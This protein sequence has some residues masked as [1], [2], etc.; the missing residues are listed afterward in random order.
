M[1]NF[2]KNKLFVLAAA[3]LIFIIIIVVIIKVPPTIEKISERTEIEIPKNAQLLFYKK[4]YS[5]NSEVT[6]LKFRVD[7][8][9]WQHYIK[10]EMFKDAREGSKGH[11][12]FVGLKIKFENWKPQDVDKSLSGTFTLDVNELNLIDYLFDIQNDS[13]IDC[14]FAVY[15]E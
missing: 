1:L 9:V 10:N 11:N 8:D 4:V 14:Y 7:K 12:E 13:W 6:Y 2:S 3:I 15:Q 5:L